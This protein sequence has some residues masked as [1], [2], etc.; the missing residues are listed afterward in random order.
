TPTATPTPTETPTPTPTPTETP[1]P[2]PT[3]TPTPTPPNLAP[4]VNAGPDQTV[5]LRTAT[6]VGSATDDGLPNPPGALTYT[7]TKVTGPGKVT[8]ADAKAPS[9]TAT[10]G[11]DGVYTLTLT[12]SDG[13]LSGNDTLTV[14]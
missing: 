9:T 7:W 11:K 4:I 1:T 13:T 14:I 6:L 5:P 2:T 3:E 10:F 12:A 8:F